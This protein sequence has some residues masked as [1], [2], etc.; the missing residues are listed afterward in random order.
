[1]FD[2]DWRRRR[3]AIKI[4]VAT[5][6]SPGGREAVKFAA[7]LLRGLRSGRA[8]LL[9]VGTCLRNSILGVSGVPFPLTAL[10]EMEK[11]ERRQ[12]ERILAAARK[13]AGRGL[14]LESRFVAPRDL[15]PV[16]KVI[17]R[18]A[19]RIG[20]DLVVVGSR[21]HATLPGLLLGSVAL[22]LLHGCPCPVAVVHPRKR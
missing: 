14:R 15:A 17:A 6:G 3:R 22:K 12:A 8:H 19:R 13:I 11:E 20:A 18:E 5:D 4:L 9:V 16:A 10:P 21:G 7:R 1:V 2:A